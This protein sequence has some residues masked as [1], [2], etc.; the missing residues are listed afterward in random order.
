MCN[1]LKN[2]AVILLAALLFI[3]HGVASSMIV[4]SRSE[5]LAGKVAAMFPQF[6]SLVEKAEKGNVT[7]AVPPGGFALGAFVRIAG[8]GGENLGI[9]KVKNISGGFATIE[10]VVTSGKITPGKSFARGVRAPVRILWLTEGGDNEKLASLERALHSMNV[11]DMVSEDYSTAAEWA[12]RGPLN[13][14]SAAK[15]ASVVNADFAFAASVESGA[16]GSFVRISVVSPKR[17]KIG[18][19]TGPWVDDTVKQAGKKD[20]DKGDDSDI[21]ISV[22]AGGGKS[23]F[24]MKGTGAGAFQQKET[25]KS[26]MDIRDR[27]SYARFQIDGT[28]VSAALVRISGKDKLLAVA[29]PD[30]LKVLKVEG[31]KLAPVGEFHPTGSGRIISVAVFDTNGSGVDEIFVNVAGGEQLESFVVSYDGKGFAITDSKLNYYFS[32]AGDSL[33]AQKGMEEFPVPSGEVLSVKRIG[34]GF[35]FVPAFK[36]ESDDP[37]VGVTR[38]DVDGD[39]V[40]D[41]VGMSTKGLMMI[42]TASGKLA[43]KGGGFGVSGKEI[44]FG[45]NFRVAAYP[46]VIPVMDTAAG[47]TLAVACAEYKP[48]GILAKGGLE[49]ASIKFAQISESGY[50][51]E[52]KIQ[53]QEGW[54][55][56]LIGPVAS[57]SGKGDVMGYVL[58]IPGT[59]SDKSEIALP[60]E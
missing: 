19:I 54:I 8:A 26:V 44:V 14:T 6:T 25:D 52:D 17:G 38:A 48:G 21:S 43:W 13:T 35:D 33:L 3:S 22:S 24:L 16:K 15:A 50:T 58:S 7:I 53:F 45:N 30:A 32:A 46:R 56:E 20:V 9:G 18:E 28:V 39:G 23:G 34:D 41:I 29:F 4:E 12:A 57:K 59:I 49:K 1:K 11:F 31:E 51:V 47:L 55:S 60:Q 40:K 5:V 36:L 37:V 42:Y 27:L 2:K 10:M